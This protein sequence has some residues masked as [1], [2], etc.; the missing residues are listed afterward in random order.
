[1]YITVKDMVFRINSAI[2]ELSETQDNILMNEE[3]LDRELT[4]Q[5]KDELRNMFRR[6]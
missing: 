5:E 3:D 6:L 1:M 2:K 4:E